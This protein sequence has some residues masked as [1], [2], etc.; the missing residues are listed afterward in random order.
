VIAA[1]LAA[2]L[3]WALFGGVVALGADEHDRL[4]AAIASRQPADALSTPQLIAAAPA[5]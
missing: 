1:A 4:S 3:T 5:P 2:G